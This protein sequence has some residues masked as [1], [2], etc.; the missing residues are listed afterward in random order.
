VEWVA[1]AVGG[2]L[3][4]LMGLGLVFDVDVGVGMDRLEGLHCQGLLGTKESSCRCGRHGLGCGGGV[5]GRWGRF[6]A[7]RGV[8]W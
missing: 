8:D 6:V 5:C 2:P 7:Y 3:G 1:E 4:E